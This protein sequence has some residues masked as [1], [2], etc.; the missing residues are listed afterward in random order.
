M[1]SKKAKALRK[2]VRALAETGDTV[3]VQYHSDTIP[4]SCR[5][6]CLHPDSSR[7]MYQDSKKTG[8]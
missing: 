5:P 3:Y 2:A 6:V 4:Q 7:K 8:K 1:N